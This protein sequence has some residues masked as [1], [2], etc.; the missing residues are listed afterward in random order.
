MSGLRQF[1]L[2]A[3]LRLFALAL[4]SALGVVGLTGYRGIGH[5]EEN[6]TASRQYF[7]AAQGMLQIDKA[8]DE[9]RA[10]AYRAAH[11]AGQSDDVKRQEVQA[12]LL[13][14]T[15]AIKAH[16]EETL[17]LPLSEEIKQAIQIAQPELEKYV[18]ATQAIITISATG[19]AQEAQDALEELEQTFRQLRSGLA[20]ID[21]MLAVEVTT[22]G[23][24]GMQ[25]ATQAKSTAWRTL[26]VTLPIIFLL[27]FFLA[28]SVTAPL[29]QLTRAATAIARG[30]ITQQVTHES[31]DE[32]GALAAAFRHLIDYFQTMAGAADAIS[33]G[34][35]TIQLRARSEEDVLSHSFAQMVYTLRHLSRQMQHS[36]HILATAIDQIVSSMHQLAATTNETATSVAETATTVEEIK[37]TAHVSNQKA[38]DVSHGGQ[39]TL[40]TSQ[41]GQ[42]AVEDAI[43]G[44][45]DVRTQ[46]ESIAQRVAELGTQTQTIGDIIATVNTLAEQSHLLAINAA[47][48]AAKAGDAG[49]GFAVVAQEVRSLAER[50]KRATTEV[51]QMLADIRQAADTAVHVTQQGAQATE[52]GTQRSLQAGESIRSLTQN[53]TE[54]AQAMRQIA[55]SSQQQLIGM[56]QVALAMTSIKQAS[57]Q[58]A[59]GLEQI[60]LTAQN[61]QEVSRTLQTLTQQFVIESES[62]LFS[63]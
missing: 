7:V 26:L 41:L 46:M 40:E 59:E 28:R 53:I 9:L 49:K 29:A 23:D 48:E 61:L 57:A 36:T 43:T 55:A 54:S 50:S 51:Q 39:Q 45:S 60:K 32:I 21:N 19:R 47:I 42:Q 37:Q 10:L 16:L 12:D 17:L 24:A 22:I 3:K 62:K 33:K 34:D 56:D 44:M 58:N 14:A 15:G 6:L 4:L 20:V 25:S 63:D 1:S 13:E 27:G 2:R 31:H 52:L 8:Q 5:L 11:L 30:S 18:A 38:Q 35:L